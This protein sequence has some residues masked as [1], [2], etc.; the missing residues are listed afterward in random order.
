MKCEIRFLEDDGRCLSA[1]FDEL[2][3]IGGYSDAGYDNVVWRV[4]DTLQAALTRGVIVVVSGIG[5]ERTAYSNA[6][7]AGAYFS[8][9]AAAYKIGRYTA[10][11]CGY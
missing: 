11:S 4:R 8:G 3:S 5:E 6:Q 9:V 1:N 7:I 2:Y 10:W